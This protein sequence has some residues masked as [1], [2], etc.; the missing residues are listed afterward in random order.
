LQRT[1]QRALLVVIVFAAGTAIALAQEKAPVPDDDAQAKSRELIRQIY[2]PDY[3]K[4]KSLGEKA[5]VARKMLGQ[6]AEA[7]GD[8]ANHFVLLQVARTMAIQAAD[9]A[10]ALDAVGQTG[11]HY[12]VDVPAIQIATVLEAADNARQSEHRKAVV[13]AAIPLIQAAVDEDEYETANR[14]VPRLLELAR[15]SRD[16][17]LVRKMVAIKKDAAESE[18][19][20]A[21]VE[22]AQ[23]VL[24]ANPTDPDA[25]LTVGRYTCL[26]KGDWAKGIPMLALG[27]DAQLKDV[28]VKEL[29]GPTSADEEMALG[30]GSLPR[31]NKMT[32]RSRLRPRLL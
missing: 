14:L 32:S 22:K 8:P 10:T 28:A 30:D 23:A 5:A 12:Q 3:E 6:A 27:S 29:K 13:Q 2:W 16:T 21:E 17:S 26:A 18:I 20:Y 31:R 7:K 19:A 11:R 9:V 24:E 1:V 4:A 25:N 15:R